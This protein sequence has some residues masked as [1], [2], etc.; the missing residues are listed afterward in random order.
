[1]EKDH[2]Y[3]SVKVYGFTLDVSYIYGHQSDPLFVLHITN[4]RQKAAV[5]IL[6]MFKQS[7]LHIKIQAC[8]TICHFTTKIFYAEKNAKKRVK[9]EKSLESGFLNSSPIFK[10]ILSF[11]RG[12]ISPKNPKLCTK[13]WE[14]K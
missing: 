6:I 11:M 2:K 3:I 5:I 14:K 7:S 4:E 1:M 8:K 13:N 10:F 12:Q 9:Q